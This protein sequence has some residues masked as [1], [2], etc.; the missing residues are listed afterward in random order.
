MHKHNFSENKPDD[1]ETE[2]NSKSLSPIHKVLYKRY[3]IHTLQHHHHA[4]VVSLRVHVALNMHTVARGST[5][6]LIVNNK[7]SVQ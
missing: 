1:I 6:I 2:I 3:Q 5:D 7:V 4:C